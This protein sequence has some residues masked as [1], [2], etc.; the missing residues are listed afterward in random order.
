MQEMCSEGARC[1]ERLSLVNTIAAFIGNKCQRCTNSEK[2]GPPYSREQCKQ[3]CAFDRKDD[4]NKVDGKL[5]CWL[6]T[7]SYKPVLQKTKKQRKHL[8]SSS[9]ASHQEKE[10]YSRLSSGS[11][12][13]SFSP[14]LALD[15]P[16][17]NHLVIIA[18]LKEKVATLKKMLHQKDQMVLEKEKITELKADFQYQE[19]D[20]R[21]KMNQTEKTH[22]EVT[23][24]SQAKNRELMKQAAAL[25][26]S[27]KSE[28]SGT[29]TSP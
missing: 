14:D 7:L 24:Q 22:K 25:S 20:T 18:Q 15:S 17:T 13:N 12:Y 29:I 27:K 19:S 5:L 8:S 23:E 4:L 6:C 11:H 16:G 2:Y 28:K 9:R 1:M 3:Q 10:Q 26:K 21:A